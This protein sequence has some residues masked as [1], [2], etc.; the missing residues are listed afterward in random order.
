MKKAYL[1]GLSLVVIGLLSGCGDSDSGSGSGSGEGGSSIIGGAT[2]S[3]KVITTV[4]DAKQ[5]AAAFTQINSLS[6]FGSGIANTS[7]GPSR[8]ASLAPHKQDCPYGGTMTTSG[9]YSDDGSDID[10]TQS[11][12]N[13]S[14]GSG[15]EFDGSMRI[16]QETSGNDIS[17]RLDADNLRYQY[18]GASYNMN[19]SMDIDTN[20]HY[21]PMIMLLDGTISMSDSGYDFKAEYNNFRVKT[22]DNYL[23]ISGT[24][25]MESDVYSCFD[26]TYTIETL[27]DLYMSGTGY[28]SGTMIVN[29]AT[30]SYSGSSVEITLPNGDTSTVSQSELANSCN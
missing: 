28:S 19:F 18:G 13:C 27:S 1:L 9:S 2:S 21:N 17:M 25:S 3:T 10:M 5:A 24:V 12:N 11:Y 6:A 20:T 30:Y 29:G 4:E 7:S 23:N 22:E 8:A 26:G 14:Q 15:M 16:Q